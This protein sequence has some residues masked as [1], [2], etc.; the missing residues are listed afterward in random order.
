MENSQSL[1]I[2][3]INGQQKLPKYIQGELGNIEYDFIETKIELTEKLIAVVCHPHP[4]HGGTKDNKVVHTLCRAWRDIGIPCLRFNFRGV[5][6]SQGEF[7]NG[8]GEYTDLCSVLDFIKNRYGNDV[9][10]LLA[11]FSFGAYI[12][13]KYASQEKVKALVLIAPPVQY[14]DFPNSQAF[15]VSTLIVQGSADKVVDASAVE[16]WAQLL[17]N[18]HISFKSLKGASHFFHG[19]L[20]ELKN[21]AQEFAKSLIN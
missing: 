4:V 17:E 16:N 2:A 14:D 12:A 8:I 10:I 21:F 7:N 20:G 19:R 13:T 1:S 5:G 3:Q 9:N 15:N 11:G 6:E 18:K